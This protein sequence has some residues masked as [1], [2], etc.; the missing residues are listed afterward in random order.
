M[1][2][3]FT[4]D[5]S[6]STHSPPPAQPPLAGLHAPFA[7]SKPFLSALLASSRA[8][9]AIHTTTFLNLLHV[10]AALRRATAT[11]REVRRDEARAGQGYG[12]GTVRARLM[13]E[14]RQEERR[15]REC[16]G[17]M[18]ELVVELVVMSRW[19]VGEV[20]TPVEA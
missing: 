19:S 10:L 16:E 7:P 6:C 4:S 3:H 9:A 14:R 8:A 1:S 2:Y 17:R 18:G 5:Y 13:N 12:W 20:A 15:V 11:L